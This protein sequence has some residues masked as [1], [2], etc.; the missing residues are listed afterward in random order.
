[1]SSSCILS[2]RFNS[3]AQASLHSYSLSLS[4]VLLA[5][6]VAYILSQLEMAYSPLS[7]LETHVATLLLWVPVKMMLLISSSTITP[8]SAP[9]TTILPHHVPTAILVSPNQSLA[10]Y[11]FNKLH[12]SP[13][14]VVYLHFLFPHAF[15]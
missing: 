9:L 3:S 8:W 15:S 4:S 11:R 7:L 12:F 10:T 5:V 2:C 1:M 13:K 6:T 14:C